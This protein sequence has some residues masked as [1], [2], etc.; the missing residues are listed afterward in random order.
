MNC[1]F[2][3]ERTKFAPGLGG[4]GSTGLLRVEPHTPEATVPPL[5]RRTA[6]ADRVDDGPLSERSREFRRLHDI[7]CSLALPMILPR[8]DCEADAQEVLQQLCVRFEKKWCRDPSEFASGRPMD[9]Y[10][11]TPVRNALTVFWRGL[12][13]LE[14]ALAH[15]QDVHGDPQEAQ[16]NPL[17]ELELLERKEI[18]R[19][20]IECVVIERCTD[21]ERTLGGSATLRHLRKFCVSKGDRFVRWT[22]LEVGARGV[23]R[24]DAAELERARWRDQLTEGAQDQL[25]SAA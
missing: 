23:V 12:R 19:E 9:S 20:F 21:P 6:M 4:K 1:G 16:L 8:V 15:Y 5:R 10:V 11:A 22:A 3:Q 2:A 14:D 18:I 24:V 13:R 7:V 25:R 17:E